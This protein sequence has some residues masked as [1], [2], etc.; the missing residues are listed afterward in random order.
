VYLYDTIGR[1]YSTTR[2]PDARVGAHINQ[3]LGDP[4]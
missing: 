1:T 2:R 3:A 4:A